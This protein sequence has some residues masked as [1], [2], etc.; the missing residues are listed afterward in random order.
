MSAP[1]FCIRDG[2]KFWTTEMRFAAPTKLAPREHLLECRTLSQAITIVGQHPGA[3]ASPEP[4]WVDD[5]WSEWAK[6]GSIT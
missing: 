2:D 5:S 3:E 4:G 6:G 1:K